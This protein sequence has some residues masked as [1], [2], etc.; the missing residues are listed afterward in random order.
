MSQNN[1]KF[2]GH[3]VNAGKDAEKTGR[4][5]A[6][7]LQVSVMPTRYINIPRKKLLSMARH[8][9]TWQFIVLAFLGVGGFFM[10][11]SIVF[12]VMKF[13]PYYIVFIPVWKK[14]HSVWSLHILAILSAVPMYFIGVLVRLTGINQFWLIFRG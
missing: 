10:V 9:L 3:N 7:K 1:F 6:Q 4:A 5:I 14:F 12:A 13:I 11:F 8:I 2:K